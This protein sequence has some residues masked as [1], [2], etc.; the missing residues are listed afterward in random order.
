MWDE[1]RVKYSDWETKEK[2]FRVQVLRA[3]EALGGEAKTCEVLDQVERQMREG[4]S[5]YDYALTP[6]GAG[7]RWKIKAQFERSWMVNHCNPPLMDSPEHGWWG[8]TDEGRRYLAEHRSCINCWKTAANVFKAGCEIGH[9]VGLEPRSTKAE[10]SAATSRAP[11]KASVTID[12]A[13]SL[14]SNNGPIRLPRAL[15][16]RPKLTLE[17]GASWFGSRVRIGLEPGKFKSIQM[18]ETLKPRIDLQSLL[19]DWTSQLPMTVYVWQASEGFESA[20][21]IMQVPAEVECSACSESFLY[22]DELL[23]HVLSYAPAVAKKAESYDEYAAILPLLVAEAT[24]CP[25]CEYV[26]WKGTKPDF[27]NWLGTYGLSAATVLPA[28]IEKSHKGH[29]IS[30]CTYT[31]P[32]D[33]THLSTKHLPTIMICT[34]C[35]VPLL[36]QQVRHHMDTNHHLKW[37]FHPRGQALS[38]TYQAWHS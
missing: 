24:P 19:E 12:G 30:F 34:H 27:I 32:K 11:V 37:M 6:V 25:Y 13:T 4:L 31:D 20:T 23:D 36:E 15:A 22:R 33:L 28:H 38:S 3:L 17:A 5:R 2:C 21:P 9:G 35:R 29:K 1:I 10:I 18:P 26:W 16:G 14:S 8:I 7:I